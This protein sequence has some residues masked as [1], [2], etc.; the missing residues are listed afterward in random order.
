MEVVHVGI[1][2]DYTLSNTIGGNKKA[3]VLSCTE[4]TKLFLRLKNSQKTVSEMCSLW[5]KKKQKAKE[6]TNSVWC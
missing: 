5:K 6:Q 4:K 1:S 2:F 3:S